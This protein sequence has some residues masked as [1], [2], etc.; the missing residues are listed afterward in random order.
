MT[1]NQNPFSVYDFLGYLVPGMLCSI[2]IVFINQNP[3]LFSFLVF[4]KFENY[5]EGFVVLILCYLLG[6]LLSF[7]SSITIEKYSVWTLGYPSKYLFKQQKESFWKSIIKKYDKN[8][9][10]GS[11][12]RIIFR[13]IIKTV[14]SLIILPI[15]VCDIIIRHVFRLLD[16]YSRPFDDDL[17]TLVGKSLDD[18][19]VKKFNAKEV[20]GSK[21]AEHDYFR[22]I[23]HYALEKANNHNHKMQNYVSLYGFTRTTCFIFV[24]LFW[25]CIIAY[26]R[27]G[28]LLDY[29][30]IPIL[31]GLVSFIL[32]IDF[33]KFYR[34]YSVEAVM[35]ATISYRIEKE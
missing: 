5:T 12:L 10:Y 24:A 28:Y 30:H 18:L 16:Q 20:C 19:L 26:Y 27:N 11:V 25:Y 3:Y 14:I 29:L 34:K 2:G 9:K 4:N 7:L 6:H 31:I 33:N 15:T 32:Y 1:L 22:I 35:A 21:E 13:I 8:H 17:I 23:Y